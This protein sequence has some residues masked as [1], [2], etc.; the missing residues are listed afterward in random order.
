MATAMFTAMEAIKNRRFKAFR[1]FC[2]ILMF[3]PLWLMAQQRRVSA[4]IF[5]PEWY[6]GIHT[7]VNMMVAEGFPSYNWLQSTGLSARPVI[8]YQFS[9]ALGVRGILGV[10]SH[11]WND[12]RSGTNDSILSFGSQTL[13]ADLMLNVSNLLLGY[14]L[15]APLDVS[16][17]AGV[18]AL[19]RNTI[20]PD[21]GYFS[22]L[23]RGG[24]QFDYRF[25]QALELNLLAELNVTDDKFNAFAVSTPV[26]MFPAVMLGLTWHFRTNK[27]FS[28]R[29]CD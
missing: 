12:T 1:L 5:Q 23:I 17:F 29:C 6:A 3:S 25:N 2:L 27:P 15:N 10:Q 19:H 28:R 20:L 18:G 11:R 14:T 9:P 8:G 13:Q 24:I 26:D 21:N 16:I 22:Y 7:G 4:F